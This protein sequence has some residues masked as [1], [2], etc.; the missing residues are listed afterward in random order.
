MKEIFSYLMFVI[1]GIPQAVKRSQGKPLDKILLVLVICVALFGVLMVYN[2]S[3]PIAL[4]DF[5]DPHY[6]IRDQ[7]IWLT[8]GMCSLVF[9][10]KLEYKYWHALSVPFLLLTL[11]L[12][13][14]VFFP[15]IGMNLYGASRWLNFGLFTVQ[16]SEVTKLAI[17]LYLAAWL[18]NRE[19]GQFNAFLL[20]LGG[21]VGLVLLQ[22]D[23]GTSIILLVT[24]LSVYIV[25]GAPLKRLI[26]VAPLVIGVFVLLAVF[27]PYRLQRITTFFNPDSDPL[28]SSYQIR[29]ALLAIGSGGWTGVGL[30]KSRQKYEYLPEA[31]TDAIFAI[32]S[33]EIGFIGSVGILTLYLF[34][35]YRGFY[36]ARHAPDMFGKLL[37]TGIVSW[38]GFQ[39]AINIGA[40]VKLMPLTGVPLPLI[41]YGG[42]SFIILMTAFGILLN[43]SRYK[44]D[45]I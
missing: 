42:S 11:T 2:T 5:G 10:S 31:N 40:I 38:F 1:S 35:I 23:M 9:F 45:H 16:P 21:T 37:A 34:I 30:G 13:I 15:V 20:F 6:F 24:A 29:Q 28:G 7:L 18:S 22:P 33:E 8:I 36:V 43:I 19:K 14:A 39:S 32:I 3:V 4:R 12:L 17:C 41:S 25:S 44:K 26:S 27:T